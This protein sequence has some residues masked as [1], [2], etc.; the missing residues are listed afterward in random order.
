MV[1]GFTTAP[2]IPIHGTASPLSIA[3][4]PQPFLYAFIG[5]PSSPDNAGAMPSPPREL[6]AS[7]TGSSGAY[8]RAS[9]ARTCSTALHQFP[10]MAMR[11]SIFKVR[12]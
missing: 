3:P 11:Q 12:A 10:D 5:S 8:R 4:D 1:H 9:D 6:R 7:S 2:G